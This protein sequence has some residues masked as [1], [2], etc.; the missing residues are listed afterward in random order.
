[1]YSH[2]RSSEMIASMRVFCSAITSPR[3]VFSVSHTK[4]SCATVKPF[5]FR[6]EPCRASSS[7]ISLMSSTIWSGADV[8]RAIQPSQRQIR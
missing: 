5:A 8:G 1:M 7:S 3:L 6:E 4:F 2:G